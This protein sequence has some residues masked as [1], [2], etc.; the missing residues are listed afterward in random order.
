[1]LIFH[2]RMDAVR[3]IEASRGLVRRYH[4]RWKI[5]WILVLGKP[6]RTIS[7]KHTALSVLQF[8]A[9]VP[10]FPRV[11]WGCIQVFVGVVKL[12]QASAARKRKEKKKNLIFRW[13][14]GSG[15]RVIREIPPVVSHN[16]SIS[17]QPFPIVRKKKRTLLLRVPLSARCAS[18]YVYG[19]FYRCHWTFAGML[20]EGKVTR[21]SEYLE[22]VGVLRCSSFAILSISLFDLS[23]ST[24]I[25]L[26]FLPLFNF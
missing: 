21:L 7:M 19:S 18:V 22:V 23:I 8:Y 2:S 15:T 10:H 24:F 9:F 25:F 26:S 17:P 1:M 6:I 3:W 13:R 20:G 11:A 4:W 14:F 5:D 12:S 16:L